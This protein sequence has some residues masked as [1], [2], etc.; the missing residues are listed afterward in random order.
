MKKM[1]PIFGILSLFIGFV[2]CSN[3]TVTEPIYSPS[4][5]ALK[6]LFASNLEAI[7]QEDVFDASELYTFTSEKGVKVI[8][9][10]ACLKKQNGA[11]VSGQVQLKYIEIFDRG[12]M[13]ATNKPTVGLLNGE[14]HLLTSGGEFLV[15]VYQN[16]EEL[17]TDCG[18]TIHAPTSITGGTDNDMEVFAGTIDANDNLFWE[19]ITQTTDFWIGFNQAS[20]EE[21][22][23]AFVSNFEWFNYDRFV[24]LGQG[25]TYV[26]FQT[27]VGFNSSNSYIFMAAKSNPHALAYASTK[28]PIGTEVYYIL[29]SEY[30]GGFK[31][32]VKPVATI[33]PN[34][35]ITFTYAELQD[36]SIQQ[37][38]DAINNLP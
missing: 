18:F 5:E 21:A 28:M 1:L 17:I 11:P 4:G 20:N 38:I 10:G 31:Y 6:N 16:G 19:N 37:V 7:T 24:D 33:S 34:Q 8:I 35:I 32:A 14:P 23:N 30:N 36:G 26:T 15:K 3:D 9:N 25:F 12:T 29:V 13:L 22:Y 27:P 2:S